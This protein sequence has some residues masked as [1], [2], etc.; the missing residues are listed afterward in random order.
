MPDWQERITLQ[1][2]PAIL[3]EHELR[4]RL[5]APLLASSAAWADLGC[6]NGVA[7]AAVLDGRW[8]ARTVLVDLE[9]EA[10]AQAAARLGA[11][12]TVQ[13]HGD[14]TDPDVLTRV[15]DALRAVEGE[16]VVSCFE[17][18]EHLATFSPLLEWAGELARD[19]VATFVLSVPN[20]AFWAIENPFHAARWGEGAFDELRRLL[21]A[22]QT[23]MR[24]VALTG[25]AMVGWDDAPES[26]E[27]GVQV[28]GGTTVASHFIAAFGPRHRDVVRE[29]VAVPAAQLEQRRWERQRESNLAVAEARVEAL[30]AMEAE[31][32]EWRT[33]IHELERELG[34]PLSGVDPSQPAS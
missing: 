15:G 4:Y 25:S 17:V 8:P 6:G 11:T 31:R 13:L 14:L 5:L 21:P 29:A 30:R 3:S 22:E 24:Q 16:R 33:Y 27:L 20:D 7:P 1:T 32:N 19:G 28:G 9:A 10:V 23:L 18:V 34:R 12:D 2:P 26:H